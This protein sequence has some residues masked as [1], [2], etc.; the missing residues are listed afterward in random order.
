MKPGHP[1]ADLRLTAI[2]DRDELNTMNSRDGDSMGRFMDRY[3]YIWVLI[4]FIA[5]PGAVVARIQ[6][7]NSVPSR[8]KTLPATAI[9]IPAPP[10]PLDFSPRG[11]WLACWLDGTRNVDRCELTDYKGK[12]V[13]YF[14]GD[15]GFEPEDYSP[16]TGSNPVPEARLHLKPLSSTTELWEAVG[17]ETVPIAQLQD[18]TVLVPTQDL[19]QLREHYE[20]K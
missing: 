18:G 3:W 14:K 2:N 20:S 17:R 4:T 15:P 11:Y 13:T 5:V 7:A 12:E 10:A 19:P 1:P 16:V 6:W 9:W 8:P